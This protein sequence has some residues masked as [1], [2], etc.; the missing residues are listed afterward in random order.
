MPDPKAF[1]RLGKCDHWDD[2]EFPPL[3]AADMYASWIRRG[4]SSRI[5]MWNVADIYLSN[6]K[7]RTLEI[8]RRFLNRLIT[9]LKR[10]REK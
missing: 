6:I 7:S 9:R 8:D 2:Q 10:G 4:T 1:T 3:Q 5:Q